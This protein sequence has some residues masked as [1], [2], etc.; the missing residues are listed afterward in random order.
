MHSVYEPYC[1]LLSDETD[2][3]F[4]YLAN[5]AIRAHAIRSKEE[6]LPLVQ[7]TDLAATRILLSHQELGLDDFGKACRAILAE[8]REIMSTQILLSKVAMDDPAFHFERDLS[9]WHHDAQDRTPYY[10]VFDDPR[11]NLGTVAQAL[12]RLFCHDP[13]FKN[14]YAIQSASG[15]SPPA[16]CL[17]AVKMFLRASEQAEARLFAAIH[18]SAGQPAHGTEYE[19]L[20]LVNGPSGATASVYMQYG[21]LTLVFGYHK[22]S[23]VVS[24]HLASASGDGTQGCDHRLGMTGPSRALSRMR[25]HKHSYGTWP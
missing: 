24:N 14:T 16:W 5:I 6:K 7:F 19:P 2:R 18:L 3:P 9:K 13:R 23:T 10:G 11:N 8:Y 15:Q 12:L 1:K 20:M 22:M 4:S 25:S 17:H 21:Y